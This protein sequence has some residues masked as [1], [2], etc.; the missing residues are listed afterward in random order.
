VFA[1]LVHGELELVGT[2]SVGVFY[3]VLHWNCLALRKL[4]DLGQFLV[5]NVVGSR[6]ELPLLIEHSLLES[7]LV[8]A[9]ATELPRDDLLILCR[10]RRPNALPANHARPISRA[11]E[12]TLKHGLL[13]V[14]ALGRAFVAE[15]DAA[16]VAVKVASAGVKVEA[17]G[18]AGK[19]L[20]A[21][22]DRVLA[23]QFVALV[24]HASLAVAQD[25]RNC[26]DFEPLF[27]R[28]LLLSFLL[29]QAGVLQ[30]LKLPLHVSLAIKRPRVVLF[31]LLACL[32]DLPKAGEKG[33]FYVLL[34]IQ[35]RH[36]VV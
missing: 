5:E 26:H 20:V 18:G 29:P 36:C 31:L 15:L 11:Q 33:C 34:A 32:G 27:F 19:K 21:P 9:H 17:A 4:Q 2:D 14:D 7:L 6:L 23:G 24:A 10:R 35:A 16:E 8:D 1:I 28:W 13:H 22:P 12:A 25:C 3:D 30:H